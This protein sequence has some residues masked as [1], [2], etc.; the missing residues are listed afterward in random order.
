M[1]IFHYIF[2]NA[3][4]VATKELPEL[5]RW[6]DPYIA[7]VGL[8]YIEVDLLSMA[9]D[10]KGA[11]TV[12]VWRLDEDKVREI[13]R[14]ILCKSGPVK[15]AEQFTD[16]KGRYRTS[17]LQA[18]GPHRTLRPG[19]VGCIF[20]EQSSIIRTILMRIERWTSSCFSA[21]ITCLQSAISDS[22]L[23]FGWI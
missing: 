4:W 1:H 20:P 11:L 2:G 5:T 18:H 14:E 17:A 13:Q 7:N 21:E 12:G 9:P 23:S 16:E 19:P 8:K 6:A 3:I 15:T 22:S 10:N